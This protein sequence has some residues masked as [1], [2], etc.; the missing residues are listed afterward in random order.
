MLHKH[1]LVQ[2]S[3]NVLWQFSSFQDFNSQMNI[4]K[5]NNII[6]LTYMI[7]F[8]QFSDFLDISWKV[9]LVI[10]LQSEMKSWWSCPSSEPLD[11]ILCIT[12]YPNY[13]QVFWH[14]CNLCAAFCELVLK[15]YFSGMDCSM[16]CSPFVHTTPFTKSPTYSVEGY[17]NLNEFKYSMSLFVLEATVKIRHANTPVVLKSH[18]A[19]HKW[20]TLNMLT[21]VW[22]HP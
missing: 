17:I 6:I 7:F 20:E 21:V 5:S 9:E 15:G 11:T 19:W 2:V 16:N 14:I 18:P 1:L 3:S 22:E 10:F 12:G 4:N 8:L 13:F